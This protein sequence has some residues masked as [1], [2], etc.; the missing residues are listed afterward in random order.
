MRVNIAPTIAHSVPAVTAPISAGTNRTR[1]F[2][3]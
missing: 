1:V 2:G 3:M